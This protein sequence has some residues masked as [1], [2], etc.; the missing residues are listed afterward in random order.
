MS[1]IQN[2]KV[3]PREKKRCFTLQSMHEFQYWNKLVMLARQGKKKKNYIG[4]DDI[5]MGEIQKRHLPPLGFEI[6]KRALKGEWSEDKSEKAS[7]PATTSEQSEQRGVLRPRRH[8]Y[9]MTQLSG[10]Y[11]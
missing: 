2:S 8:L 3:K 5:E 11:Y 7:Q 10:H 4:T 1:D 6:Q 9:I